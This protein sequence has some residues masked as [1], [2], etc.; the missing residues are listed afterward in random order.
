MGAASLLGGL[1][2][3]T[4]QISQK[5][6]AY[7]RTGPSPY[8]QETALQKQNVFTL[9]WSAEKLRDYSI[10]LISSQ[11]IPSSFIHL[12]LLFFFGP[13]LNSPDGSGIPFER[14]N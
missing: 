8:T 4:D 14:V 6:K 9:S 13:G 5:D 7:S 3:L 11:P 1:I 10:T 2:C 12:K